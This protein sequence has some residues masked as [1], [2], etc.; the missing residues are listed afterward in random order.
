ML[1]GSGL[2]TTI[3]LNTKTGEVENK[4][5]GLTG[6][7]KKTGFNT[8]NETLRQIALL[9]LIM[10]NLKVKYLSRTRKFSNK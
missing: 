6:L 8:K 1:D 10:I 3:G 9:L 7:V 5:F 4:I 2:V